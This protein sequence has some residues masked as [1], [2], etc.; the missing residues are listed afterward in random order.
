MTA[1]RR[2]GLLLLA[3]ALATGGLAASRVRERERRVEER[4]GPLVGVLVAAHNIEADA[5]VSGASLS[6]RRVP[7]RFLPPDA[8]G[9]GAGVAGARTA[10]PLAAGSYLTAGALAGGGDGAGAGLRPGERAV[11][12]GVAGAGG[13]G[14]V[15]PD[16]RVDVIVSTE[17]GSGGGRSLVAL[18]DVEVLR[19]DGGADAG[20]ADP[21]DPDEAVAQARATLRVSVR[22]AVYLTAADNFGREI[23]LL[24]RPPGD[25][26]RTAAAVGAGEL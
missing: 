25:R 17:A 24:V 10:V 16:T 12:V 6:V 2:R 1:R 22:Q 7:A 18:A 4:V 3:I 14:E 21:A 11:E 26:G 23:R 8:I 5:R 9:P 15:R 19:L 20:Y 13:L